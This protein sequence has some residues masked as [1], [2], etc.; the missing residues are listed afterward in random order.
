MLDIPIK[1]K[2]V[3]VEGPIGVGKTTLAKR[4][5]QSVGFRF[6]TDTE[7]ENPYLEKFY[8]DPDHYSFHTQIDFLLSRIRALET[9]LATPDSPGF[10]ADFF[11]AKDRLFAATTLDE[12]EYQMYETLY[13]RLCENLPSPDLVIY[14]QAPVE[15]LI[16][17]IEKRGLRFEQRMDSS[18]LQRIIDGYEAYF[19]HYDRSPLLVVNASAINLAENQQD[20]DNLLNNIAEISA[21]R[22]YLNPIA[23][24]S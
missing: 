22:H 3:S 14:L 6:I 12:Q 24:I 17:R 5:A 10:V 8:R 7:H 18:Y 11:L 13:R 1:H 4:L 21:G 2:F 9:L 16:N 20:Y 23:E 15:I 19:H